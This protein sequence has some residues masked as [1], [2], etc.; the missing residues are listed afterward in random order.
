MYS[1]KHILRATFFI[2]LAGMLVTGYLLKPTDVKIAHYYESLSMYKEAIAAYEESL[3]GTN[4]QDFQ[5]EILVRISILCRYIEDYEK[6]LS[7][8]KRLLDLGYD[9]PRL[10]MEGAHIARD[11]WHF[12]QA[13]EKKQDDVIFF[14]TKSGSRNF[15]MDFLLGNQRVGDAL[16]LYDQAYDSG[17]FTKEQMKK[18]ITVSR[19]TGDIQTRK[20]WLERAVDVIPDAELTRELFIVSV[21][22]GDEET[23]LRIAPQMKPKTIEDFLSL[24]DL[25]E[26]VGDKKRAKAFYAKAEAL[27]VQKLAAIKDKTSDQNKKLMT[28]LVYL[29]WKNGKFERV[30]DTVEDLYAL[31]CKD[32]KLMDDAFNASLHLWREN[33]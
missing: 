18:A 7:T 4:D 9:D 25:H 11:F 22:A 6:F 10:M 24:A 30:V 17:N 15:L 20:R 8:V 21:A 12:D 19:W 29:Y 14:A 26:K 5:K 3:E 31:G 16:T 32:K 23:A 2:I 1:R 33:P 28:E 13:N 27:C